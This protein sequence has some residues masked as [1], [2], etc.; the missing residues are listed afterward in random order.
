VQLHGLKIADLVII[1]TAGR[2]ND[3]ASAAAKAADPILPLQP[4]LIDLKTLGATL[5]IIRLAGS[6]GDVG[7]GSAGQ[8]ASLKNGHRES[9]SSSDLQI[10][11][12]QGSITSSART[13]SPVGSS[14]PSAFAVLRLRVSSIFTACWTGRCGP[15]VDAT[16]P[17]GD[18]RDEQRFRSPPGEGNRPC[19]KCLVM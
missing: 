14:I 12:L 5:D 7:L 8:G 6:N 19:C 1:D 13:S 10:A 16:D 17:H 3:A 9:A 15:Q 4:S 2:T 18:R 11:G